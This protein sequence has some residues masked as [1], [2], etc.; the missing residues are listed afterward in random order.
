MILAVSARAKLNLHLHIT[1][2]AD[3]GFHLLDSLVVFTNV[4]DL[5]SIEESPNY[6]LSVTGDFQDT[7]LSSTD[8]ADNLITR[9]ALA[10]ANHYNIPPHIKITLTK[11]IPL[12]AGLGGG[13][14]DAA[15]TL[16]ALCAFWNITDATPVLHTIAARLASDIAACLSDT[17][18]IMRDTGNTLRPA[19]HIPKC[20]ILLVNPNTPCPTPQVYGAYKNLNEPFSNSIDFPDK[21]QA[22]RDLCDFL[23]TKTHNDLTKAAIATNPDVKRVLE[24]L[25]QSGTPLLTRLSGSGSTCYS[26]HEDEQ[27]AIEAGNIIRKQNP[28][29]W[30]RVAYSE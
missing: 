21:F 24:C 29:W 8:S 6:A 28:D 11:S 18:V 26:I 14:A 25:G 22:I 3:N 2:R 5:I 7:L 20:P 15:A 19:P 16:K 23:N 12:G 30:V 10:L 17:P 4:T 9:A 13:S 1:G 27:A